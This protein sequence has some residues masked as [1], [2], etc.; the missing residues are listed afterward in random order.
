MKALLDT[1][2]LV[3]ALVEPH[4]EH[5]RALPW[6]AK[7]KSSSTELVISSHTIA[8]LYAVLSTLPVS[9]R[10]TPGFAWRLIHESIEP[11][12]SIV[13]LTTSEYIATVRYLSEI[14]LSGGAVYDALIV[15]AAQKAEAEAHITALKARGKGS[16]FLRPVKEAM[17][18][19]SERAT[20][21][22]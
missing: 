17:A 5:R 4:P 11:H 2:V 13:S 16:H 14:G 22:R 3:A 8:E 9:P 21:S 20:V 19:S 10:I 7:A 15:K 6:L 12:V 18:S 1:S